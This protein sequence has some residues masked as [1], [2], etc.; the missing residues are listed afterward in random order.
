MTAIGC[1][2][3]NSRG[4]ADR[5]D[6][7]RALLAGGHRVRT[8]ATASALGWPPTSQEV[9]FAGGRNS[10]ARYKR[11]S[12]GQRLEA[13]GGQPSLDQANA[14]PGRLRHHVRDLRL[15]PAHVIAA[16][17]EK[18]TRVPAGTTRSVNHQAVPD[19]MVDPSHPTM[20]FRERRAR[21]DDERRET[22]RCQAVAA[23][24]GV[25]ARRGDTVNRFF[26]ASA[27]AGSAYPLHASICTCARSNVVQSTS[28]VHLC[29]RASLPDRAIWSISLRQGSISADYLPVWT[30]VSFRTLRLWYSFA[31]I[32]A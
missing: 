26:D 12:A 13:A 18:H 14:T 9:A 25:S 27:A 31:K 28:A 10:A 2:S 11:H 15:P 32:P 1:T 16:L 3:D 7:G 24:R 22:R 17:L 4:T 30:I 21:S 29:A 8:V 19:R 5:R 6:L 20:E 23:D